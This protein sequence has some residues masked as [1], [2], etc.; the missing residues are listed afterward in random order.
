MCSCAR[1]VCEKNVLRGRSFFQQLVK[2]S[3][4]SVS[5]KTPNFPVFNHIFYEAREL[6]VFDIWKIPASYGF[7]ESIY[8][9]FPKKKDP[10][11]CWR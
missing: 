7:G 11:W 2:L 5:G 1:S 6:K 10:L 4:L 8:S 3:L 9:E